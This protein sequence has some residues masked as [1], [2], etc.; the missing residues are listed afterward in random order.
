[1]KISHIEYPKSQET[2]DITADV[3]SVRL[4]IYVED[5]EN[6]VYNAEMQTVENR[7]IPKITRYYQ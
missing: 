7:N 2:I 1:M 6:T 5:T 4:D 3:K